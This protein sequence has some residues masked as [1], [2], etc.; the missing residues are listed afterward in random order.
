[1]RLTKAAFR[2]IIK[3]I[4]A[5]SFIFALASSTNAT[6]A[7]ASGITLQMQPPFGLSDVL[8]WSWSA[9]QIL[10]SSGG[11]GGAGQAS[12]AN[13]SFTRYTDSQSPLFLGAVLTGEH[14][15]NA[16]FQSGSMTITLENVI[17]TD[18]SINIDSANKEP[19][20]ETISMAFQAITY[21]VNG[22]TF[23]YDVNQ[24]LTN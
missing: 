3:R 10:S 14:I 12:V 2:K 5:V 6:A 19:Q 16:V 8:T 22:Q 23:R 1:M 17:V 9:K 4:F 18:Y 7:T 13:V 24:A 20:T 21:T 15:Q 11:G